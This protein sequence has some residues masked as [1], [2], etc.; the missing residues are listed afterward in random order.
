MTGSPVVLLTGFE[1]FGGAATNPSWEAASR[2][3]DTWR[4]P[5]S[6]HARRI[7]VTFADGPRS[8]LDAVGETRPD[9]VVMLG[10]HGGARELRLERVAVNVADARIPDNAGAQPVDEPV[11]PGGPVGY[12]STLPLRAALDA[13]RAVGIPAALSPSAGTY[14]CNATFYAVQHALASGDGPRLSGFVHVPPVL[15]E[16]VTDDDGV[17][18][19]GAP[20]LALGDLVRGVAAVVG[21]VVDELRR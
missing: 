15:G 4:G 20:G 16:R 6:V 19:D 7:P 2:V 18:A 3:A 10:L 17:A 1:P 14:V 12:W 13:A 9:A 21:V 8:V 5:G 11:V